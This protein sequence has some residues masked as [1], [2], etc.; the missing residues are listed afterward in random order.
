MKMTI[1]EKKKSQKTIHKMMI[2][3][4]ARNQNSGKVPFRRN[5]IKSQSNEG[6]W[7]LWKK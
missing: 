5:Q 1:K 3:E 6:E 7:K 2:V 4:K